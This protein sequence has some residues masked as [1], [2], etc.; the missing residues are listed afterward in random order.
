MKITIRPRGDLRKQLVVRLGPEEKLE[1]QSVRPS[2]SRLRGCI[3]RENLSVASEQRIE[4]VTIGNLVQSCA[5]PVHKQSGPPQSSERVEN[6]FDELTPSV[7]AQKVR[8][9]RLPRIGIRPN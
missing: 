7:L 2:R 8:K 6:T 9:D 3:G 1:C 5:D 4:A